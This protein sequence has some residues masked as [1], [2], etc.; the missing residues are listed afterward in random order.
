[1]WPRPAKLCRATRPGKP[2][3]CRA[4]TMRSAVPVTTLV[5]TL[6]RSS[7]ERTEKRCVPSANR[8]GPSRVCA[9]A[10]LPS[11]RAR[12]VALMKPSEKTAGSLTS[13]FI[14]AR[15]PASSRAAAN[16]CVKP[17]LMSGPK[18]AGAKRKSDR[19]STPEP[20]AT[21]V[22]T[23]PP[24]E[25]PARCATVTPCA[26][27]LA[28]TCATRS[29]KPFA[30]TSAAAPWPGSSIERIGIGRSKAARNGR[31]LA[32]SE[33][34]PWIRTSGVPSPSRRSQLDA[35]ASSRRTAAAATGA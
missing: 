2:F 16:P 13:S 20:L 9:S 17:V 7:S 29:S 31:Q 32:L 5:R 28:S 22:A 34:K 33:P 6:K 12:S 18:P 15:N 19:A 8:R 23:P 24:S 1:M 25:W 27:S 3:M 14:Q 30:D 26:A 35:P 10:S 21:A 4:G 11:L